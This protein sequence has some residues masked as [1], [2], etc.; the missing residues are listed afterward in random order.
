[1]FGDDVSAPAN[2]GATAQSIVAGAAEPKQTLFQD[3][4]GASAF[5]DINGT[6]RSRPS[7]ALQTNLPTSVNAESLALFD[8]PAYLMPP[9]TSLYEPLMDTLIKPRSSVA[10]ESEEQPRNIDEDVEMAGQSDDEA[11][12]FGIRHH[13]VVNDD[14]MNM[15]ID[16]FKLVKGSSHDFEQD[17][18]LI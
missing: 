18:G 4:F 12:S 3:M 6:S 2:E 1:M 17:R 16:L 9:I 11:I 8:T 10:V 7:V 13:R 15:F 14:E 5:G